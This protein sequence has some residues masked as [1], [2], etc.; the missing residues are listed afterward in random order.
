MKAPSTERSARRESGSVLLVVVVLAGLYATVALSFAASTDTQL[1]AAADD[2]R[3]L[4]ADLAAQSGVEYAIRKLDADPAW[5]GT[6]AP[7]ALASDQTFEITVTPTATGFDVV[8]TGWHGVAKAQLAASLT[9]LQGGSGIADKALAILGGDI[10]I[11]NA[12]IGGEVLVA[13]DHTALMDWDPVTQSWTTSSL[14][15]DAVVSINQ[16]VANGDVGVWLDNIQGSN[17]Y[18]TT[19]I[20]SGSVSAPRWN[21]DTYT[22]PGSDVVVFNGPTTI[23][24]C[25]I[26]ETVVIVPNEG[27][28]INIQNC[29]LPGGVVVWAPHDWDPRSPTP[30]STVKV[31]SCY[32]GGGSGGIDDNIGVI[33]P[34]SELQYQSGSLTWFGLCYFDRVETLSS[35][36]LNGALIVRNDAGSV[37]GF[38]MSYDPDVADDTPFGVF[39]DENAGGAGG[40]A[41]SS[42]YEYYP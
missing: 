18:Y 28:V 8:S 6:T 37:S 2:G 29:T 14:T 7:L 21:L 16:F 26:S 33:A 5:T 39:L 9:S 17:N 19:A 22:Q 15:D 4:R 3:A 35:F 32:V 36:Y 13:N 38:S 31:S 10:A 1:R 24:N 12:F 25:Y 40:V 30:H 41:M 34:G 11:S 27:D 42:V 20:E 23:Q